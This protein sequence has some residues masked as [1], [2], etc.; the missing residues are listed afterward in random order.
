MKCLLQASHHLKITSS[1]SL[2]LCF[3]SFFCDLFLCVIFQ[4][5]SL[6]IISSVASCFV[7]SPAFSLHFFLSCIVLHHLVICSFLSLSCHLLLSFTFLSSAVVSQHLVIL[8]LSFTIK[9]S[10]DC[11]LPSSWH[12]YCAVFAAGRESGEQPEKTEEEVKQPTLLEGTEGTIADDII[13]SYFTSVTNYE[14]RT[15]NYFTKVSL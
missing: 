8:L 11:Y 13:A 14:Y 15:T 5:L 1:I 4:I 12:M 10:F 7:L 9:S 3:A 6:A 2:V